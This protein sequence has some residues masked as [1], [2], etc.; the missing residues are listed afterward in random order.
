MSTSTAPSARAGGSVLAILAV[1]AL[2]ALFVQRIP[3]TRPG[4]AET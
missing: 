4:K 3:T 2:S 1:L